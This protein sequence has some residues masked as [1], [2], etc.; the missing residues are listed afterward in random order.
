MPTKIGVIKEKDSQPHRRCN[1]P[2]HAPVKMYYHN[3]NL[4]A[5]ETKI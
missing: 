1:Q 4:R 2:D 3:V 5:T